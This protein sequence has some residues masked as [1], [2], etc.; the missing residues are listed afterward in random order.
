VWRVYMAGCAS[1]FEL[2]DIGVYQILATNRRAGLPAVPLT[3]RDLY[4][5]PGYL[6]P[7]GVA[8]SP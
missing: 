3:R 1:Q 4:S 6:C 7:A 8:I 2:G 5:E